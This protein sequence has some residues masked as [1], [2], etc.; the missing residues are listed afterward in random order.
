MRARLR[1]KE[2]FR[3]ALRPLHAV[4]GGVYD[5]AAPDTVICRCEEV[6]RSE[7]DAAIDSSPDIDVIKS[8]T[9][10]GMGLCQ[11]K[12]CQ[13]QIAGMVAHRHGLSPAAVALPT[14]RAP[15]RPVALAAIADDAV[16]DLGLFVRE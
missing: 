8:F 9:R 12:T 15:V 5:L 3:R 11:G 10:V 4:G 14:P 2:A 7:L 16:E 6:T 1:R 13:R